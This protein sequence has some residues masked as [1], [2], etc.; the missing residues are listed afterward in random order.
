MFRPPWALFLATACAF[1]GCRDQVDLSPD[2]PQTS[3]ADSEPESAPESKALAQ[4]ADPD[5]PKG[6]RV[7]QPP[8][9]PEPAPKAAKRIEQ[10]PALDTLT[11]K[12]GSVFGAHQGRR[13]HIQT[14]KPLYTPGETIW[15]KSLDLK[16]R[17]LSD[18]PA[19]GIHYRL[20]SPR[21]STVVQQRVVQTRGR[22]ANGIEIPEGSVGGLYTLKATAFDGVTAERPV[23]ISNYQPPR[24]QK[25]LEFVRK[26]YGAGDT[27]KATLTLK[28]PTGDPLGNHPVKAQITVDGAP[29]KAQATTDAHGNALIKFTLPGEISRG[30]GLLTVLVEQGGITESISRPIPI[31]VKAVQLSFFPEGGQMVG[32]L[33]TRLYFEARTPLDK[34]ADVKGRI[35]DDQGAV[36]ATFETFDRGRGRV[37]FTPSPGR[38][39]HGEIIRPA[40]ISA[41]Y[42]LPLAAAEGCVIRTYDDPDG[43]RSEIPVAVRCTDAQTVIVAAT[44]RHLLLDAAAVEARSDVPIA[45]HLK[46]GALEKADGAREGLIH[47]QGPARITLFD[48]DL[49][50]IAER[51]VF[52]NRRGGLKV[53]IT[54]DQDGYSPR[55]QVALK[56]KTTGPSGEPV[57]AE[58]ALSVVD[59]KVLSFADDKTGHLLSAM[60]L[61][62]E[63]PGTVAEPNVYF[64]LTEPKGAM[65]LEL[66]MGTRGWRRFDWQPVLAPNPRTGTATTVSLDGST[67][68]PRD[69]GADADEFEKAGELGGFKEEKRLAGKKAGLKRPLARRKRAEAAQ[70]MAQ[71]E[72]MPDPKPDAEDANRRADVALAGHKALKGKG[73]GG[74]GIERGPRQRNLEP[75]PAAKPVP[76]GRVAGGF[77]EDDLRMPAEAMPD[78]PPPP[79][80]WAPVR[81]FPTPDYSGGFTGARTDFR[82]TIHWAPMVKTGRDGEATVTFWMSDAVTA[83][84][85]TAEGAGLEGGVI[86]R[87][88]KVIS[89][90][91]PFNLDVKLPVEVSAG[92]TVQLPITL[93]NETE[94]T[95]PVNLVA[96]FG[97]LVEAGTPEGLTEGKLQL[98]PKASQ[99][100]WYPLTVKGQ[101]G[102][103]TITLSAQAD[104]LDDEMVRTLRVAPRGFPQ[105]AE[106]SGT[107][108]GDVTVTETVDLG[109]V[110]PGSVAASLKLYPSPVATLLS[111]LDGLVREPH[112][113]FE[114]TSSSNYPNVMVLQYLEAND[115]ADPKLIA[116]TRKLVDKGYKRLVGF[117][118]KKKGYEWFG[119][120]PAHE[121]LTAYGVLEFTDMRSIYGEVDEAMLART[122]KWLAKRRDGKGGF[123]RDKKALDSFGRAAPEITD[124]Y[125]VYSLAEAGLVD[126][127]DLELDTLGKRAEK[128]QDDYMLALAANALL[129]VPARRQAGLAL[130]KTLKSRQGKDGAWKK[131]KHSITR[132][133]GKNLHIETTALAMLA[134]MKDPEGGHFD[135]LRSGAKWL[136]DHRGG[137]GQWGATQAT[138]LALK[139]MTAYSSASA[140]TKHPGTV[141]VKINGVQVGEMAY[142]AGRRDPLEFHAIGGHFKAGENTIEI[143]HK[144]QGQLP[145]S[146]AA[147]YRSTTPATDPEAAVSVTTSLARDTVPMGETVRLTATVENRLD[148]GQPMTLARLGLPGGLVW[149]Q[150]QLKALKEKGEVDFVETRPREVIVYFR[151]MKP[152]EKREI[153]LDLVA[154]VPGE[155]T[156]PASSAY[157]YYT[158]DKK[159]WTKGL[160]VSITR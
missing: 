21:G 106:R 100:V 44:Q 27:V 78:V 56:L 126:G 96:H 110:A 95:Q 48:A 159:F 151:Q 123:K 54:P 134:L 105:V 80:Q 101:R 9:K 40:G 62:P 55:E 20:V 3:R 116:R 76:M 153:S 71:A 13:I 90:R 8:M 145:F 84:R 122:A 97:D 5:A 17:D 98:P 60:L 139:A 118:T 79:P 143:T 146:F 91:L 74:G 31:V 147:D 83:F 114:Q 77:F 135:A 125:I 36:V 89:A 25:K 136:T 124:A 32:G 10:L 102:E 24:V 42:P 39:Y 93:S 58:L 33:P 23:V 157:L 128:T 119:R 94:G 108:K 35:V 75:M 133:S 142:E 26:A 158:N 81:V 65:G 2:Q 140:T 30:D 59:D 4:P 149:Q 19:A 160:P 11:Q 69:R 88:E 38:S 155:F 64:D 51:L 41:R 85:V 12:I 70:P 82:E 144:G 113:C 141:I 115:V 154:Q 22:A 66:L 121:A 120:A 43:Q 15:I 92:D 73:R 156:G 72:A 137:Y 1:T 28:G 104:G 61:A 117:E 49:R 47:A 34:P 16:D 50:P 57:P 112:G 67:R 29:L 53:E 63:I 129:S 37:G 6:A 127:F 99:S 150:W 68:A 103:S 111:G 18:S 45:V 52:R 46:P 148:A 152:K 7:V 86:G 14:D 132:S 107:L 131:A 130:L 109:E 138:V 87:A